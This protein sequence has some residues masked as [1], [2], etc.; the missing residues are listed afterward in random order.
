[1]K[2]LLTD[3]IEITDGVDVKAS[4]HEVVEYVE[5]DWTRRP[6]CPRARIYRAVDGHSRYKCRHEVVDGEELL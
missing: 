6:H 2:E 4:L 1:M 3:L 5:Y